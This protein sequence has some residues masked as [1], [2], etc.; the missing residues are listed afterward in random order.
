MTKAF[1]NV[2]VR[3]R[4]DVFVINDSIVTDRH[5]ASNSNYDA[6]DPQNQIGSIILALSLS[7]W[8][9]HG[10]EGVLQ[11]PGST[12]CHSGEADAIFRN[13]GVYSCYLDG[14]YQPKESCL[15]DG[16][17]GTARD[18]LSPFQSTRR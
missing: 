5:H 12:E 10:M 14:G 9:R 1:Y 4:S 2:Y 13:D 8:L 6:D 3:L 11:E 18:R 15:D 17:D 16:D 7:G